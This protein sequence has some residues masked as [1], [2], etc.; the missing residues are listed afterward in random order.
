MTGLKVKRAKLSR[1]HHKSDRFEQELTNELSYGMLFCL[2][3]IFIV[4]MIT[5]SQAGCSDFNIFMG[6]HHIFLPNL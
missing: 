6:Q 3:A 2:I 4:E 1:I 5:S